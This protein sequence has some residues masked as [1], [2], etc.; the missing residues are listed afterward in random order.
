MGYNLYSRKCKKCGSDIDIS[1][2]K[3]HTH[4]LWYT[5]GYFKIYH[6]CLICHRAS[7]INKI[8]K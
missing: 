2:D 4:H 6:V 8:L 7:K 1:T 3:Y 5:G